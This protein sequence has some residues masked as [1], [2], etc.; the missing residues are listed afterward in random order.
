MKKLLKLL[1]DTSKEPKKSITD[2]KD[3]SRLDD[4]TPN[5]V[6]SKKMK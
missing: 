3:N 1:Q 4:V 2:L 6:T 5:I